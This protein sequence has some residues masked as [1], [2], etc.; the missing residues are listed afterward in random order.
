MHGDRFQDGSNPRPRHVERL[1]RVV[2]SLA[3]VPSEKVWTRGVCKVTNKGL[4]TFGREALVPIANLIVIVEPGEWYA[5]PRHDIGD[6]D[7]TA[8]V[9]K[10][11]QEEEAEE[12]DP[13]VHREVCSAS[14]FIAALAVECS[15][16]KCTRKADSATEPWT[17]TLPP[18]LDV[19]KTSS[20]RYLVS[21]EK[22]CGSREDVTVLLAKSK[23]IIRVSSGGNLVLHS[24]PRTLKLSVMRGEPGV[25]AVIKTPIDG[26]TKGGDGDCEEVHVHCDRSL[27]EFCK[28]H[29]LPRGIRGPE[30][31]KRPLP[32][33][34]KD[35]GSFCSKMSEL[36]YR[37]ESGRID[38]EEALARDTGGCRRFWGGD[39]QLLDWKRCSDG[40]L[41]PRRARFWCLIDSKESLA[42]QRE[43]QV[44]GHQKTYLRCA[45]ATTTTLTTTENGT[46]WTRR[47]A[48]AA[49]TYKVGRK[50]KKKKKKTKTKTK[51]KMMMK[52]KK[53]M[54]MKTKKKMIRRRREDEI[55]KRRRRRR[56]RK[57]R[58][59]TQI[60]DCELR[61]GRKRSQ[62][63]HVTQ[64]LSRDRIRP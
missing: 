38:L 32:W 8:T 41:I 63:F 56:R 35:P 30:T 6:R 55:K 48:N 4:C 52:T 11:K 22:A 18:D 28:L 60:C 59:K 15:Q 53:K 58:R 45:M 23:E 25:H 19:L 27:R 20:T 2:L 39:E 54:M 1:R 34:K 47:C 37:W 42:R 17:H 40:K 46:P 29:R 61:V 49:H 64:F 57:T 33:S 36:K 51:K 62:V 26:T 13:I 31:W 44:S 14:E 3:R 21:C 16:E 50:K 5:S 12:K 9:L 43:A 7:S 24:D 10:G